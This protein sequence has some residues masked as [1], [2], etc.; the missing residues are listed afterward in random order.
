MSHFQGVTPEERWKN[1]LL[2]EQRQQTQLLE[3]IAQLLNEKSK[4]R[5]K[6]GEKDGKEG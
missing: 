1:D 5:G 3:Q 6:S 4:K 2:N